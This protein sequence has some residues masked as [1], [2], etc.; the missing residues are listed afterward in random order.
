M[1][2][3]KKES[4]VSRNNKDVPWSLGV[5]NHATKVSSMS[6]GH[7]YPCIAA[8]QQILCAST[9]WS[10]TRGWNHWSMGGMASVRAR[11]AASQCRAAL[12]LSR[13]WA[14]PVGGGRGHGAEQREG[15]DSDCAM[16]R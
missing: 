1:G 10:R 15:A 6:E 8:F 4:S 16:V 2:V 7:G 5:A 11:S 14:M 9:S 12:S 3:K 13:N